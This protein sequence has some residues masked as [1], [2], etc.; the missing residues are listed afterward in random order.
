MKESSI[1]VSNANIRQHQKEILFDTKGQYMKELDSYAGIESNIML[2]GNILQSTIHSF[3][4]NK[5]KK[6]H[7][8]KVWLNLTLG[9]TNIFFL[10]LYFE[11]ARNLVRDGLKKK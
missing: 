3:K 8:N 5:I 7:K 6:N 10:F 4:N 1:L 11:A 2:L 9:I